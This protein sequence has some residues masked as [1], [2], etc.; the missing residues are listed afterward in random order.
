MELHPFYPLKTQLFKIFIRRQVDRS[1]SAESEDVH[2]K[3][4]EKALVSNKDA[5]I[6]EKPIK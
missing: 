2:S 4:M 5:E 3:Q 6:N 1:E